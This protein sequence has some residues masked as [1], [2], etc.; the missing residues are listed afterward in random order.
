MV[1]EL[2]REEIAALGQTLLWGIVQGPD[3]GSQGS[4]PIVKKGPPLPNIKY[5]ISG[6]RSVSTP[7]V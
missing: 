4:L 5:C 3:V 7:L 6:R 2:D 1:M